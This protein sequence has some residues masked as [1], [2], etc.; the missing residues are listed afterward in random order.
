[1]ENKNNS[2]SRD[3]FLTG[4]IISLCHP[5]IESDIINGNWHTWF[6]SQS[7]TEFLEHGIA[8][9]SAAEEAEIVRA[10]MSKPTSLV[11]AIVGNAD[12]KLFGVISIKNIN[13]L[14]RRGEIALVTCEKRLP[15]AALEAMALMTSH[16]FDRMNLQTLY[17][18]QHEGLWKWVN[19]LALI[20]YKVEGLRRRQ[21]F[22]NGKSYDVILT[23]V[24]VDDFYQIRSERNGDILC[25]NAVTLGTKRKKTRIVEELRKLLRDFNESE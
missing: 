4:S 8:P 2:L 7:I 19:T 17:A 1:M 11:L 24:T 16:A 6:N 18:G 3:V 10:E 25:G 15:G 21:G 23:S 9:V 13:H 22:R 20:G 5:I 12:G 14:L